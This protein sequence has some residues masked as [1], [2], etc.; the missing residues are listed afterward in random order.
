MKTE[1]KLITL[2]EEMQSFW[3]M[4]DTY[5]NEL[6]SIA[7]QGDG[8]E[9]EYYYSSEYRDA[10]DRIRQREEKP[11]RLH[12]I[13]SE[14][15]IVG[16]SMYQL[17]FDTDK[18]CC[19]MEYYFADEYKGKGFGKNAYDSLE[20]IIGNEGVESIEL[21]PTNEINRRFWEARGYCMTSE[22]DEENKPI[23]K[24]VIK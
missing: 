14:D 6:S 18:N 7:T 3:S 9:L 4:F 12:F 17:L 16:F 11:I 22:I 2:D 23:Y 20:E 13:I 21:T 5:I 19:L 15:T 24:K 10:I 8:I 1:M